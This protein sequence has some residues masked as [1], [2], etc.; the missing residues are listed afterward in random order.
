MMKTVLVTGASS[1]I[2]EATVRALLEDGCTVF[3]AARRVERMAP[4]EAMGAKLMFLDLTDEAS[5]LAAVEAIKGAAGRLDVLVNNAG[6]GCYGALEDVSL[7]EARRQF[8]V[9]LFGLARLCQLTLPIMRAQ[10]AGRIVNVGSIGGKFGEPFAAWY[11]SSKFALEGLSDCLRMEAAP[12]GVHV[13]VV[14]P[15]TIRTEWPGIAAENLR[16]ASGGTA[17]APYAR[18]HLAM[19]A[20]AEASSVPSPPDVVARTIAKAV[21]A[22]RPRTRYPTGAAARPMLFLRSILSDRMF[23]RLMWGL[24]QS[25]GEKK[26]PR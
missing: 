4:L 22:S 24:S 9:N 7:A 17:Y 11:H 8:E 14:E 16:R 6:Y 15:G 20:R 23:D 1:G 21:S 12:F 18:R 26:A 19:L 10:R 2:G 25:F 5:I 3:A 13:I